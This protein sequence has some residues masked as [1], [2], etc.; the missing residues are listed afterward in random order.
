MNDHGK[1][2]PFILGA[3]LAGLIAGSAERVEA[4]TASADDLTA[5]AADMD[6]CEGKK[7]EGEHSCKAMKDAKK[8]SK[9][10]SEKK[11]DSC[12]SHGDDANSCSGPNGCD[13]KK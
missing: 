11:E 13:S 6:G 1:T 9:K 7:K 2:T 12:K 3:A 10:K 5:V 8:K 4:A